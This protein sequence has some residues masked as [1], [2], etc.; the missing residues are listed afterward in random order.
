M[1]PTIPMPI[2]SCLCPARAYS[3]R[4]VGRWHSTT[5]GTGGIGSPVRSGVIQRDQ[6]ATSRHVTG[7]PSSM[8]RGTTSRRTPRGPARPCRPRPRGSSRGAGDDVEA[9][10]TWAGKTLP[11]EAEWEF[12]A[13]GGL[14]GAIYTWGDEFAPKGRMMANTWQG[15]FPWQ[16]LKTDRFEGTAPVKSFPPN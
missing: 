11:T 6:G 12:A 2:R 9:Y 4:P 5:T 16:N 13:R 1:R 3:R 14:E 15:E 10:A 8:S 7:I